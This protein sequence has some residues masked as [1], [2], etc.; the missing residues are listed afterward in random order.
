[1][2]S[3]TL[4]VMGVSAAMS[5]SAAR[6]KAKADKNS[7]LYDAQVS[8]QNAVLAEYQADDAIRQGGIDEQAVRMRTAAT[9]SSQR[10]AMAANGVDL[11]EGSAADV[12]TTTD[13]VG[14]LDANTVRDNALRTA[15]GYRTQGLNYKDSSHLLRSGARQISAGRAAATSLLGSAGQ[16]ASSWY[17]MQK[18]GA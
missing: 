16:V 12:Q 14:E 7:L 8:E 15:W 17:G 11:N 18:V 3:P 6:Q 5:A 9:K 2:C 4:A 10:A 13:Y 1:M